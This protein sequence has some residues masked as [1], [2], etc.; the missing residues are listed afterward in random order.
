ML[1][2]DEIYTAAVIRTNEEWDQ[3][4]SHLCGAVNSTNLCKL[5][6][7]IGEVILRLPQGTYAFNRAQY[8]YHKI[9][10]VAKNKAAL[11]LF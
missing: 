7:A 8:L 5:L 6:N 3:L 4:E 2:A 11:G 10:N 9:D 1:T